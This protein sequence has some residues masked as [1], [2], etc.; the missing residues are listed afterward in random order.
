MMIEISPVFL[1]HGDIVH[2]P[3]MVSQVSKCFKPRK[4]WIPWAWPISLRHGDEDGTFQYIM[5]QLG[6]VL[7]GARLNLVQC[8]CQ[9]QNDNF[10][11]FSMVVS[12][13]L[14]SLSP[15]LFISFSSHSIYPIFSYLPICLCMILV[16]VTQL[17]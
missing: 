13:H 10:G 12:I 17:T 5:G 15:M 7:E 1:Y 6:E 9:E 2:F 8:A 11:N 16:H 3:I 14:L 4:L